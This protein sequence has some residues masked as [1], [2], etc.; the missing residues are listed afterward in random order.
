[1][2]ADANARPDRVTVIQPQTGWLPID[3]AELWSHRGLL[4]FLVLRDLK[5][6]Y[7]QTALGVAWAFLQPLVKMAIFTLF[8]GR[9]AKVPSEGVP[10]AV[11]SFAALLPWT[12]FDT[13]LSFSSTSLVANAPLLSK[14][15]LP[16]LML[17][18]AAAIAPLADFA[19]SLLLLFVLLP[20]YHVPLTWRLVWALPFIA[21]TAVT[22]LGCGL[23]LSAINVKYRDVQYTV[24][25]LMQIW[26]FLTP[27]VYPSG[28]VPPA[29]RVLYGLNPMVAAVEGFRWAA[30]PGTAFPSAPM[31]AVSLVVS[32]SLLIGGAHFFT[33][34]ER[35]FADVV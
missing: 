26:L 25:F 27:V 11:F 24:P 6:K 32:L 31:M 1:M 35:E 16:R 30:L 23:W 2:S 28:L 29:Y 4:G 7:K 18:T 9:L 19:I 15:Y 5:V 21:L 8:F 14:V 22:A 3:F 20:L 34:L 10:Y 12:Y 13:A 33:R 17:P